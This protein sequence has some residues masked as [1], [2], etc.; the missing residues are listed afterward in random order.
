MNAFRVAALAAIGLFAGSASAEMV[1]GLPI[2]MTEN[3]TVGT[4]VFSAGRATWSGMLYLD[5]GAG[6]GTFLFNNKAARAGDTKALGAF[7]AGTQLLFNYKVVT[8]SPGVLHSGVEAE[9]WHFGFEQLD[10]YTV[11]VRVEDMPI[12]ISDRDW[13]DCIAV[14]RFSKPVRLGPDKEVG[15]GPNVPAPGGVAALLGGV[16]ALAGRRRRG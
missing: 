8:G 2:T 7:S 3:N 12:T 10:A 13:D 1:F 4:A 15:T 16:C 11:T 14:L 5:T 6:L 9:T